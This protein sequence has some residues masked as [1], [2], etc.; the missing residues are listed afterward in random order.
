MKRLLLL[1]A[2][3]V[4]G[5][6][7]LHAQRTITGTV[8]DDTAIPLPGASIQ[9]KGTSLGTV[10][11]VDGNYNLSVPE[12]A[13]TLVYSFTGF[14]TIEMPI[15]EATGSTLFSPPARSSTRSS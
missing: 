5:L 15:G 1:L 6:T 2:I 11:D 10:T 13:R 8:I 3:C 7:G 9:I 4:A 14:G 12:S